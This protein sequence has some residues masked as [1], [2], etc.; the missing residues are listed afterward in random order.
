MK[1][2]RHRKVFQVISLLLFLGSTCAAVFL[3]DAADTALATSAAIILSLYLLESL[4]SS[5]SV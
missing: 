4:K 5:T 3:E 1:S 2:I